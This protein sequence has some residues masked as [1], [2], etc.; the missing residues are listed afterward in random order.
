MILENG[1]CIGQ[2]N[3]RGLPQKY[4]HVISIFLLLFQYTFGV[5]FCVAVRDFFCSMH[6]EEIQRF[7]SP[8]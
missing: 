4:W 7:D 2:K 8:R 1:I 5:K 6:D 3:E